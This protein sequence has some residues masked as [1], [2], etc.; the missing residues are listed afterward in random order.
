[1]L[2]DR[3]LQCILHIEKF[4]LNSGSFGDSS[5]QTTVPVNFWTHISSQKAYSLA[6]EMY[7]IAWIKVL[8]IKWMVYNMHI[9]R[10]QES[11]NVLVSVRGSHVNQMGH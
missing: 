2:S 11:L 5:I 3:G 10:R 7:Q 4:P 1:M 9:L 6:I 8:L